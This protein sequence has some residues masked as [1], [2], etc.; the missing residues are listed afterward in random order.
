MDTTAVHERLTTSDSWYTRPISPSTLDTPVSSIYFIGHLSPQNANGD[1]GEPPTNHWT[2]SLIV[3]E[4]ESW[5]L[6]ILSEE[7]DKPA[8]IMVTA[9]NKDS[10]WNPEND[11]VRIVQADV[12]DK[13][14]TK[15]GVI[16]ALIMSLN[17]D[18]YVP[19]RRRR[20]AS[21]LT[22]LDSD[23]QIS[24]PRVGRRMS[25]LDEDHRR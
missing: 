7:T 16:L 15:L 1:L 17:R 18:K 20:L 4:E 12:A 5:N 9:V 24:V 3:G 19:I 13:I 25:L 11:S 22:N 2:M 23:L 8:V 14:E 10:E 6:D 21:L